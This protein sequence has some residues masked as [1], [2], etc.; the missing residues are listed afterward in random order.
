MASVYDTESISENT[1]LYETDTETDFIPSATK[2]GYESRFSSEDVELLQSVLESLTVKA[3]SDVDDT[4]DTEIL[5]DTA[6]SG[7]VVYTGATVSDETMTEVIEQL[8]VTNYLLVYQVG[9]TAFL[10]GMCFL[11]FI[12]RVIKNNVTRYI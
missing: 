6:E 7:T 11:V 10:L 8:R 12:Y 4:E 2:G 3:T 9:L 5:E 1:V